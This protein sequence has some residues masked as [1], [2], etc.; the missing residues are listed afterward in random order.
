MSV[1]RV[2]IPTNF[3]SMLVLKK[4]SFCATSL[5]I[6][7]MNLASWLSSPA[8]SFRAYLHLPTSSCFS[9]LGKCKPS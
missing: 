1:T 9:C 2:S 5:T 6:C 4:C 7:W 3:P 8:A